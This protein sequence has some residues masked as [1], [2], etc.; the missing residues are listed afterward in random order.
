MYIYIYYIGV[1]IP[2]PWFAS[3]IVAKSLARLR[4]S[5]A[6][7]TVAPTFQASSDSICDPSWAMP[8]GGPIEMDDLWTRWRHFYFIW[9]T[10]DISW[11]IYVW[12]L[13][14]WCWNF[15]MRLFL[16]QGIRRIEHM[17]TWVVTKK[18]TLSSYG[19]RWAAGLTKAHISG[20][21]MVVLYEAVDH[22]DHVRFFL[23]LTTRATHWHS[24]PLLMIIMII[25]I[26]YDNNNDNNNIIIII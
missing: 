10:L 8:F 4:G 24:S 3:G 6:V 21:L 23:F 11:T 7:T 25:M 22:V 20:G 13:V 14:C 19:N 2:A 18:V 12:T 26:I 5:L 16:S 1:H 15:R 9:H 17:V